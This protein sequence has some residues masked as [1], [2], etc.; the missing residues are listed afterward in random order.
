MSDVVNFEDVRAAK[1]GQANLSTITTT[2]YYLCRN[3]NMGKEIFREEFDGSEHI[4]TTCPV[5]GKEFWI[6]FYEFC[7]IVTGGFDFFG[8]SIFCSGCSKKRALSQP[9]E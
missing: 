2:A 7:G 6:D 3:D 5:C 1:A 8:T 9:E 4:K